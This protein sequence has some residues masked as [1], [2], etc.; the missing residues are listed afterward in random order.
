[1]VQARVPV[2]Q[3]EQD[4]MQLVEEELARQARLRSKRC[5]QRETAGRCHHSLRLRQVCLRR[6]HLR[7]PR[8][9]MTSEK[10]PS[11]VAALEK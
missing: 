11:P 2:P 1:M 9:T 8:E 6:Q 4:L 10:L 3:Q 7:L 5:R